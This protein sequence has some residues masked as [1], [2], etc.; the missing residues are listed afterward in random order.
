MPGSEDRLSALPDGV[1]QHVLGFV[2]P[3]DAV[4]T[5][6]LAGRWR[7]A[8]RSI[9]RLRI[10]PKD[11]WDRPQHL[12]DFLHALLP[13]GDHGPI[14]EEAKLDF[15]GLVEEDD[16][17]VQV[18]IRRI[19]SGQAQVLNVSFIRLGNPPLVSRHLRKLELT[20][21]ALEA[22]IL[23]LASCPALEDLIMASCILSLC[24]IS[25]QSVKRLSISGCDFL[26][27][28]RP[29]I[30][31]PSLV[32]LLLDSF[33]GNVPLLGSMPSLKT[34]L[35]RPAAYSSDCC[36]GGE[37]GQCCGSCAE[38]TGDDDHSGRCVLL[39][40][41]SAAVNLE[42]VAHAGM[43][44][45]SDDEKDFIKCEYCEDQRGLCDRNFLVDDRRFSIKLDET[46][47]VDT[48]IPC[49]ARIF[50]LDKIGFSA[51]KTMEMI[52]K[53]IET[54]GSMCRRLQFYHYL[55][56]GRDLRWCPTFSNLKTLFLNDWCVA[57]DFR[58]LLCIL[59][60][61]LVLEKLTLQLCKRQ[62]FIT[63]LAGNCYPLEKLPAI[64]EH[65]NA[66]EIRCRDIDGRVCRILKFLSRFVSVTQINIKLTAQL[67]TCFSFETWLSPS[68]ANGDD[69]S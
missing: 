9:R 50:V 43:E 60:H 61:S 12:K 54:S 55:I 3:N 38:C 35:V 56:F 33:G 23:D 47:E 49:H 45:S 64:S 19:L 40:G 25:S 16:A 58:A 22:N 30:A 24:K 65:L 44:M 15:D 1:L 4:R 68:L 29:R 51:M 6:V 31:I 57:I 34:A 13:P 32:W 18:W 21:T 48:R 14:L 67:S 53:V 10:S 37:L 28:C 52:L 36:K 7:H 39:G 66:V 41:L 11:G 20:D 26:C 59:E 8:W 2:P 27:D 46:F 63:V 17:H 42:L 62:E 5:S 69:Y